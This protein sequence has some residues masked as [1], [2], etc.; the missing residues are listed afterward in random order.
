VM[1]P[2]E[3]RVTAV[4]VADLDGDGDL[5]IVV[6]ARTSEGLAIGV[7]DNSGDGTLG[8]HTYYPLHEEP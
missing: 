3:H 7:I 5:D 2:V 1:H 4:S 6:S 8:A